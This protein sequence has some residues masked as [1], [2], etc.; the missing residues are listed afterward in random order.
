MKRYKR[1]PTLPIYYVNLKLC[2][3]LMMID[4]KRLLLDLDKSEDSR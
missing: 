1:L 3:L 4:F 2:L